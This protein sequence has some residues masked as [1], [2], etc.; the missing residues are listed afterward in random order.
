MSLPALCRPLLILELVA[1]VSSL[2]AG[3][4]TIPLPVGRGEQ[5]NK[6][7]D[8][9]ELV[10]KY[11]RLDYEGARLNDEGWAKVEP[12]VSWKR[13]PDYAEINVIARYTVDSEPTESHGKYSVTVHYRLLGTYDLLGGYIPEPPNTQQNVQY[14]VTDTKGDFR[15]TDMENSLPHPSRAVML[16]WL[17]EKQNA[18]QDEVA[19][20]RYQEALRQ[21]QAQPASPFAK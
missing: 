20:K 16:K 7:L 3:Q 12:L 4:S 1:G 13:N 11:C 19:K 8:V 2:L 5:D 9:R 14:T 21:L 6:T 17:N 15:I 10:S 18:T